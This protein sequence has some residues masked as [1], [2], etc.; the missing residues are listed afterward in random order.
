MIRAVIVSVLLGSAVAGTA[1]PS[2]D[3]LGSPTGEAR[4]HVRSGARQPRPTRGP[5]QD[6]LRIALDRALEP[7]E[8]VELTA[9]AVGCTLV[10]TDRR[11]LLVREGASYRPSSG[12]RS[13]ALDR[14]LVLRLGRAHRQTHR[15]VIERAA[16]TASVFLSSEQLPE[17]KT[18]IERARQRTFSEDDSDDE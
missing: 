2:I 9:R 12:I 4:A 11:L 15:L 17:A 1:N 8:E 14:D 13:W 18:L 3:E 6:E 5:K 7:A 10:L 16:E